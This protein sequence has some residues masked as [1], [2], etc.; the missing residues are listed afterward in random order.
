MAEPGSDYDIG[1]VCFIPDQGEARQLYCTRNNV[2]FRVAASER[3][4]AATV[5]AIA[6]AIDA[7]LVRAL[8]GGKPAAPAE[9]P[10]PPAT[11]LSRAVQANDLPALALVARGG[12]REERRQACAALAKTAEG[13]A[14]LMALIGELKAP[15]RADAIAALGR[16]GTPD[17]QDALR[18]LAE[19]AAA[20]GLD[21]DAMEQVLKGM[22]EDEARRFCLAQ[23]QALAANPDAQPDK[24]LFYMRA[25]GPEE[26][27]PQIRVLRR[28]VAKTQ[29]EKL[30]TECLRVLASWIAAPAEARGDVLRILEQH[31]GDGNPRVREAALRALGES[32]DMR[33]VVLLSK[34]LDDQDKSVR[35]SA[36]RATCRLLHWE[37]PAFKDDGGFNTWRE[38]TRAQLDA[39]LEA[40]NQLE[41]AAK[42][43]QGA[44]AGGAVRGPVGREPAG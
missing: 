17:A 22:P 32:G 7:E 3:T 38:G 44:D 21:A 28:I 37:E 15:Q 10:T 35:W 16:A 39:A 43:P 9:K 31:L 34:A 40:L 26:D 14:T 6:K 5:L 33:Y 25:L 8:E 13:R 19:G 4:D 11:D 29:N 27:P 36:A 30:R 1:D 18:K 42:G 23:A 2:Y 41:A 24:L 20:P 12:T